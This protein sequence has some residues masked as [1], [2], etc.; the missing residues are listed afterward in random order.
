MKNDLAAEKHG[1]GGRQGDCRGAERAERGRRKVRRNAGAPREQGAEKAGHRVLGC[2]NAGAPREQSGGAEKLG[3]RES[4]VLR[5]Q[6][7]EQAGPRDI[8]LPKGWS[9]ERAGRR[10]IRL[11]K[12]WSAE[13]AG[14]RESRVLR[15][16][17]AERVGCRKVRRNAG[18]R[19]VGAPRGQGRRKVGA[20]RGQSGACRGARRGAGLS[21]KGRRCFEQGTAAGRGSCRSRPARSRR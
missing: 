17:G 15:E 2:R 6:G 12:G 3:R 1:R 14:C 13:R 11:P 18:R 4:R 19:K 9:A 20:P 7:T 8:R 16:Q 10:D 21:G 5:R